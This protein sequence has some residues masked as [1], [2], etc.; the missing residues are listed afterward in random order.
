MRFPWQSSGVKLCSLIQGGIGSV[1]V[2]GGKVPHAFWAKKPK[3]R[4]GAI[5]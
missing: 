3:Y 1:P 5:L 2:W 4:T